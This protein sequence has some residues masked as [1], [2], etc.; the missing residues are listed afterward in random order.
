M[1]IYKKKKKKSKS[2]TVP[3]FWEEDWIKLTFFEMGTLNG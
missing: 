1:C 3:S 2:K